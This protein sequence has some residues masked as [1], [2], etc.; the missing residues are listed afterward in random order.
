MIF[1][2]RRP[3]FMIAGRLAL[4]YLFFLF[5]SLSC[6]F[7]ASSYSS[8]SEPGHAAAAQQHPIL[9]LR[10]PCAPHGTSGISSRPPASESHPPSIG[11]PAAPARG[12]SSES[13]EPP[14]G[15]PEAAA[16][17]PVSESH[18]PPSDLQAAATRQQA[19]P[20]VPIG[21]QAAAASP[22]HRDKAIA[23]GGRSARAAAAS[24]PAS[25]PHPHR[26]AQGQQQSARPRPARQGAG[27]EPLGNPKTPQPPNPKT[28]ES[29]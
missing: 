19:S 22:G 6:H 11:P 24:P 16:R 12:P 5:L 26:W 29:K 17:G 2:F 9:R 20:S 7:F 15:P 1:I 14:I 13:H 25:E 27:A 21:P 28:P 18:E 23:A 10:V 8:C 4:P 3:A